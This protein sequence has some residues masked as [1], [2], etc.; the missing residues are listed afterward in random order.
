M[1]APARY[2]N[3]TDWALLI[4]L[5]VLWGGSFFFVEVAVASVPTF[6]IVLV[7]VGLA[8]LVLHLVLIG[9]GGRFRATRP[10]LGA[11]LVMG[12]LNNA[13]P[14]S[15]L[16][17]G[18]AQIASGLASILNATTPL[19][20]VAV[21]H[22]A[23]KDERASALKL[24]GV[25]AGIAGVT[26][27]IG[28]DLLVGLAENIP[29][30]IACLGAACSYAVAG[31]YGRRFARMG[32]A[33]LVT[34]TGQ[35]TASSLILAPLVLLIDRPWTLPVPG[36]D[37]LA[38]LAALAIL[39]TALAYVIYFRLLRSAGATNLLLVT[40]LVPVSA[41]LLGVLVLG[42]RLLVQHVAGMACIATGLTLIDG[43]LF[44]RGRAVRA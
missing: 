39:S 44:R 43:R 29:A 42:E 5:S 23:T 9:S 3:T 35:V 41:I 21:A 18:Q 19:F 36:M 22:A 40:F 10:V 16:V 11:F 37:A 38:A 4:L 24:A 15:L 30:Q 8:A 31:I 6:T 20:A 12:F 26:M 32:V 25:A 1:S 7:R 34:A 28:G 27:M 2:M 17:W 33:P 14:F 13:V